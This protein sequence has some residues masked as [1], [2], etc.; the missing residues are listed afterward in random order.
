[1]VRSASI[2]PSSAV[3]LLQGRV[4]FYFYFFL[5]EQVW[6]WPQLVLWVAL[7]SLVW[8]FPGLCV[9]LL[10]SGMMFARSYHCFSQNHIKS[11][12]NMSHQ[13]KSASNQCSSPTT[14]MVPLLLAGVA[15]A[16][17]CTCMLLYIYI[18]EIIISIK[19]FVV[20]VDML[21]AVVFAK[22]CTCIQ[23]WYCCCCCCLSLTILDICH[24]RCERRACK[25]FGWV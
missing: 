7:W 11:S 13:S 12:D 4:F 15:F 17:V 10:L 16:K 5:Q 19:I 6:Q 24:E 20:V 21:V 25:N 9:I 18:Y 22:V 14:A 2:K 23:D 3:S 1:M 8:C